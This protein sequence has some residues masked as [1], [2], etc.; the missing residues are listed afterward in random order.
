MLKI[1]AP[2]IGIDVMSFDEQAAAIYGAIR[3]RLERRGT[4]IGPLDLL[5]A[6]HAMSTNARLVT[7]NTRE[8]ERLADLQVEDWMEAS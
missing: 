5:I 6:A 8:F 2:F 1:S 4:P 7:H 3:S